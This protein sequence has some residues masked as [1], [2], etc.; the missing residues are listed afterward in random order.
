MII[1]GMQTI[2]YDSPVLL[3][4]KN[5]ETRTGMIL[6]NRK[7]YLIYRPKGGEATIVFH[8]DLNSVA[9]IQHDLGVEP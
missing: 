7:T 9:R 4:F 2:P 3:H 6:D 8:K 5:G 1:N